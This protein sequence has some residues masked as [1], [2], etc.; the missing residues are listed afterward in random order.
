MQCG[1]RMVTGDQY[2]LS[3]EPEPRRCL[4]DLREHPP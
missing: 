4:V 3:L 1:L 2:A